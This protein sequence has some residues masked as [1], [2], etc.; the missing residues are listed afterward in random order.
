MQ[1]DKFEPKCFLD[2]NAFSTASASSV[3]WL[4]NCQ[5]NSNCAYSITNCL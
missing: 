2:K 1:T 3:T 4:S 5:L